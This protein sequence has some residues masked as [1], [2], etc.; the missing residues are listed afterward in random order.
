MLNR[1]N[2]NYSL[3]L[4]KNMKL[5]QSIENDVIDIGFSLYDKVL[6]WPNKFLFIYKK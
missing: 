3:A 6:I 1:F 5:E 2:G 4:R